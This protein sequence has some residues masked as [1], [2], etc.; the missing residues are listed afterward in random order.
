MTQVTVKNPSLDQLNQLVEMMPERVGKIIF[1]HQ[2][3]IEEITLDIGRHP[4]VTLSGRRWKV[5]DDVVTTEAM[6]QRIE[7]KLQNGLNPIDKRG[8]LPGA[9]HRFSGI[10]DRDGTFS[11]MTIRLARAVYGASNNVNQMLLHNPDLG[12]L[13]MIPKPGF[14]T[15]GEVKAPVSVLIIGA[16]GT[17]KTTELRAFIYFLQR[18]FGPHV[19]TVD[20]SGDVSGGSSAPHAIM[21]NARILPVPDPSQ[22]HLIIAEA[23]ANHSPWVLVLDEMK[24]DNDAIRV[25]EAAQKCAVVCTVHG[26][27]LRSVLQNKLMRPVVGNI[28]PVT[29]RR[30]TE[31]VF[32]VGVVTERGYY[33][34]YP[35]F[36]K[37]IDNLLAGGEDDG[38]IVARGAPA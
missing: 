7:S 17:G 14:S 24:Y 10:T 8:T 12:A 36:Q 26:M 4:T 34:V 18:L 19:V 15:S 6:F 32:D 1:E 16:P 28:D 38:L 37:S 22:Q 11:G 20:T 35:N 2:D 30:T 33:I 29:Q 13:P 3:D 25:E 23:I 9:L 31:T 21:G 5:I 27:G